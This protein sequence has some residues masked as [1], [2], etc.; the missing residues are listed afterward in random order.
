MGGNLLIEGPNRGK[1]LTNQNGKIFL[2]AE[3]L[4]HKTEVDNNRR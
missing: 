2:L 1:F 3:W 4:L